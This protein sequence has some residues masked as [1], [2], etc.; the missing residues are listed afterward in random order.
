MVLEGAT[1]PLGGSGDPRGDLHDEGEG[2][3]GEGV[4]A[5]LPQGDPRAPPDLDQGTLITLCH[6]GHVFTQVKGHRSHKEGL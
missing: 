1:P 4:P 3:E 6:V 2:G 5:V